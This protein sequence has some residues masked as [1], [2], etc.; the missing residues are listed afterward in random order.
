M[1]QFKKLALTILVLLIS[2]LYSNPAKCQLKDCNIPSQFYTLTGT[3]PANI[4]IRAGCRALVSGTVKMNTN[5]SLTIEAGGLL[6][7]PPG[8][9]ITHVNDGIPNNFD[10]WIGIIIKGHAGQKQNEAINMWSQ[11]PSWILSP[12]NGQ[13]PV[14]NINPTFYNQGLLCI[15]GNTGEGAGGAQLKKML[16]GVKV[17]AGG[18]VAAHDASFIDNINNSVTFLPYIPG[19]QSS[20]FQNCKFSI[21]T[22]K[23]NLS[24]TSFLNFLGQDQYFPVDG[25]TFDDINGTANH[26]R[27]VGVEFGKCYNGT[28][29]NCT[30]KNCIWGINS[31]SGAWGGDFSF[32]HNI[33]ENNINGILAIGDG[34]FNL[35][36][37][38]FNIYQQNSEAV[39][40]YLNGT[41]TFYVG[42]NQ[43]TGFKKPNGSNMYGVY[44]LNTG[45]SS[46]V[47][48]NNIYKN[49][50]YYLQRGV[51]AINNNVATYL[52]CNDFQFQ[53]NSDVNVIN[54]TPVNN[55]GGINPLQGAPGAPAGNT[56]TNTAPS[57]DLIN[58]PT[59]NWTFNYYYKINTTR[60]KPQNDQT[61]NSTMFI[62]GN[63]NPSICEHV[64]SEIPLTPIICHH[65]IDS[66]TGII[67]GYASS[68]L[69]ADEQADL[70][71]QV[72]LK[73][74]Y[75]GM[76]LSTFISY[77]YKDTTAHWAD[78]IS[79]YIA[80]C[81]EKYFRPTKINYYIS[82]QQYGSAQNLIDTLRGDTS[83]SENPVKARYYSLLLTGTQNNFDSLWQITNMDSL[84]HVA[85]DTLKTVSGA[86]QG[87]YMSILFKAPNATPAI[88][89]LYPPTIWEY[90]YSNDSIIYDSNYLT[91]TASPN[92]FT[93]NIG[94]TVSNSNSEATDFVIKIMDL[95]AYQVYSQSSNVQGNSST[96]ITPDT[97]GLATGYYYAIVFKNGNACCYALIYKQ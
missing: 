61:D 21:E 78:S 18:I 95:Q 17:E 32:M 33:H 97:S 70:N 74:Y 30:L 65:I 57:H 29:E 69:T 63:G 62:N 75:S 10:T 9:T 19:Y 92:P 8:S 2:L 86:A 14:R 91:L 31:Y 58:I 38:T 73:K 13:W 94:L 39:G 36:A 50:F 27:K 54:Q 88:F 85:D 28:V 4:V 23:S 41:G 48:K 89:D 11:F 72:G 90:D 12:S 64:P 59:K 51:H 96:T 42:R 35:Q 77:Q 66:I 20:Y 87:L 56:F 71:Y 52:T 67:N 47:Y 24:K 93:N 43:F 49:N 7:M 26:Q 44:L 15:E 68:G 53:I 6:W 5:C 40:I 83:D 55:S 45:G 60:A 81:N 84:K 82:K 3:Y 1:K 79:T 37:N 80:N 76:L 46:A 34:L 16:N 25:C 22:T